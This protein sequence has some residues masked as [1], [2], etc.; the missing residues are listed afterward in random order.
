MLKLIIDSREQKMLEFKNGIFGEFEVRKLVVADYGA[1]LDGIELPLVFERK[2]KGD[3]YGTMTQGYERFRK[4]IGKA[5]EL[6]IKM[7]LLIEGSMR[8]IA[9][10]YEHSQFEGDSMLKKLAMLYV[11]Y[12]LEY[13]FFNDRYEMARHIEETFDAIRRNWVKK[14]LSVKNGVGVE[15]GKCVN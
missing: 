1:E 11:R 9:S 4:Q 6:G 2:G 12:D 7:V 8:E 10:G 5:K 14:G 13:H 3:L 15:E